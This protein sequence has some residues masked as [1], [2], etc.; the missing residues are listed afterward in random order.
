[1]KEKKIKDNFYMIVLG[2]TLALDFW[3]KKTNSQNRQR[4]LAH[5]NESLE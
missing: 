2:K 1:M 4:E 3:L 5:D